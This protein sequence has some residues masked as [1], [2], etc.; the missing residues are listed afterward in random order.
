MSYQV[1][2][3]NKGTMSIITLKDEAV[4][5]SEALVPL[6]DGPD[7]GVTK[8]PSPEADRISKEKEIDHSLG[9]VINKNKEEEEK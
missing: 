8:M 2:G 3:F 1:V 9:G 6:R 7:G 5:K 4:E